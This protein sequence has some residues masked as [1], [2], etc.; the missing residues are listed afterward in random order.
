MPGL[1]WHIGD[2]V[3]VRGARWTVHEMTAWPD[4]SLLRLTPADIGRSRSLLTPYDR[5]QRLNS[6][7]GIR[8]VRP[9]RWLH[10]LRRAGTTLVPY[11]GAI[12]AAGAS[13]KL[14]PTRSSRC[15][16][17]CVTPQRAC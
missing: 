5:P 9:R 1:E 10:D 13:A 3:Q 4:C 8:I 15:S 16:R 6:S 7:R 11:G 17:S 12:A 2:H 14:L